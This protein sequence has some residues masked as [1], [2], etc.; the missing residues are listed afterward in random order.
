MV[1]AGAHGGG[2]GGIQ[3]FGKTGDEV[4]VLEHMFEGERGGKVALN[5]RAPDAV[6]DGRAE[7][8]H[9][10]HLEHITRVQACLGRQNHGLAQ[11]LELRRHDKVAHELH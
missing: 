5:K 9:V 1:S 3:V 2:D 10:E 4:G 11:G 6:E 7:V 8:G